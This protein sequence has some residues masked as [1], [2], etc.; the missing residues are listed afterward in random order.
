MADPVRRGDVVEIRRTA[1]AGVGV[2]VCT[3]AAP[4]AL[5][6]LARDP[7]ISVFTHDSD[8]YDQ[9]LDL[10]PLVL[11]VA[12]ADAVQAVFGFGLIGI[13]RT[14]PSLATFAV[15][16]GLLALAAVP[17]GNAGGLQ[18]LWLSLAGANLLLV[19]GQAYFFHTRSGLPRAAEQVPASA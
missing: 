17:V 10:L 9:V 11:L 13:R 19:A 18:A 6:V 8:L 15:C 14:M 5:L 4:A 7:V 12:L 3:V 16:Y 2:A 1:L